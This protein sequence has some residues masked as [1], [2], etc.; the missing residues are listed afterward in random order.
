MHIPSI[1][2]AMTILIAASLMTGCA[3]SVKPV[4]NLG[5]KIAGLYGFKQ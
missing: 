1:N 5:P 4:G 3:S 2:K